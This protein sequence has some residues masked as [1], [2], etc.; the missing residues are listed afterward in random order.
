MRTLIVGAG[1]LGIL[2]TARLRAAGA[3][4]WL[5]TR[6]E[7]GAGDLRAAGLRVEGIGGPASAPAEPVAPLAAYAGQTFD[8]VVLA[9]KGHDAMAAAPGLMPLLA[10]DGI[11][12][13]IQNGGVPVLLAEQLGPR[14]LGGL[15][16]LGAAL[17]GTGVSEQRNAGHLL[18]GEVQGGDSARAA[19]VRDWLGQGPQVRTTAN[20]RG[21][22][23]SKLLLNCAVT[24]LGA[25][26]G[27]T[28]RQYLPAPGA[29]ELFDRVYDE[30]LAVAL[31]AGARPETMLVEPVPGPD[32][33][34]WR[35]RVLAGYGDARP[36]MLLDFERGRRTE[37]DFINGYVADLG[38]RLGVPVPANAA[39]AATVRA[40]SRGELQPG[41]ETLQGMG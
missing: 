32:R 17:A 35:E 29:R 10:L 14:V 41:L 27:C 3:P 19:Q 38:E 9:T 33:D 34:A 20:F 6:D 7:A 8:L 28:M 2:I 36:S 26:A 1:A 31:A 37:I 5:A 40:I 22:V 24:T 18:I 25:V 16:N 15:S 12:L 4:A 30:A 21:A 23:W 39:V 13:P 11:L